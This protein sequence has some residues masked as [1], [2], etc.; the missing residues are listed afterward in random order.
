[1]HGRAFP[2][3]LVAKMRHRAKSVN[4]ALI[5]GL[6]GLTPDAFNHSL[7]RGLEEPFT[8]GDLALMDVIG[9]DPAVP[10]P[11]TLALLAIPLMGLAALRRRL[12][13]R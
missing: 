9:Y 10:E 7:S 4:P 12:T 2:A 1:M 8:A 6:L 11:G 5:L 13:E 3:R